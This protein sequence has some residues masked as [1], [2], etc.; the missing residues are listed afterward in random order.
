[1][2]S[3][4]ARSATTRRSSKDPLGPRVTRVV[5]TSTVVR[6][7]KHHGPADAVP[8]LVDLELDLDAAVLLAQ[9][10]LRRARLRARAADEDVAV[11]GRRRRNRDERRGT[12]R[13]GQSESLQVW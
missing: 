4:P 2:R 9:L 12:D 13:A 5:R 11:L 7:P 10:Q 6:A 8:V 3:A 1:M